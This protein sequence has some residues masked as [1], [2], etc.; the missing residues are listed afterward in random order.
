MVIEVNV[1]DGW[2]GIVECGV[3]NSLRRH[4]AKMEVEKVIHKMKSGKVDGLT[5][6]MGEMICIAGHAG[7]R[8]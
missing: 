5:E 6:L 1:E 8:R 3:V 2:D 4:M 7:V